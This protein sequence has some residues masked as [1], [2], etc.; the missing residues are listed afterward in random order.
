MSASTGAPA[1]GPPSAR[2]ASRRTSDPCQAP[3]EGGT[4]PLCAPIAAGKCSFTTYQAAGIPNYTLGPGDGQP[5]AARLRIRTANLATCTTS[6]IILGGTP[7][8]PTSSCGSGSVVAV[9]GVANGDIT[10]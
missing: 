3:G 4:E 10:P 2:S 8:P 5:T 1:P 6:D 7:V 9:G